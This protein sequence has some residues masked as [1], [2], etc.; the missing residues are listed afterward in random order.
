[1]ELADVV[2]ADLMACVEGLMAGVTS[3]TADTAIE[4]P[5]LDHSLEVTPS[6]DCS[7]SSNAT[8]PDRS[9]REL[10]H[11]L[12]AANAELEDL[13]RMHMNLQMELVESRRKSELL[14]AVLPSGEGEGA[15][16][17]LPK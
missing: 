6:L 16:G 14:P 1:M 2:Q 8:S 11:R 13:R 17:P 15:E 10:S 5:A 9:A 4:S 3:W 12:A 7:I